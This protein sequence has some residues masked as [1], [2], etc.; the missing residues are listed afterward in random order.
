MSSGTATALKDKGAEGDKRL[1]RANRFPLILTSPASIEAEAIRALRTRIVAQHIQQGRR[2][3]ALCAPETA[4]GCTFVA[5]NLATSLSQIGIKTVLIDADLRTP[6]VGDVFGLDP[7]APGLSDHLADQAI[8]IDDILVED[9]LPNLAVIPGGSLRPN[10]QE[11]LSGTRFPR[12]LDQLLRE[13][14]ITLID[15]TP[16][17]G[18]TDALRVANVAGYSLIVSRKHLNFLGDIKALSQL[19]H[20]D[21]SQ[22]I[23]TVLNEY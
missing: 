5:T 6:G 1:V 19:L 10:P 11:L 8:E 3:L 18:C 16:A 9:A 17:N 23:G 21:R 15:S 12:L 4:S 7:K 22:L 2:S 14:D 20:A 13:Y